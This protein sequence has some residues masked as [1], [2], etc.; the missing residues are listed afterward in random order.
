MPYEDSS[1]GTVA[2]FICDVYGLD[3]KPFV[4][5]PRYILKTALANA[6][7]HGIDEI[8]VG[9]EQE[10][11][12][13]KLD[14]NGHVTSEFADH[15][16]YFDNAPYD[17]AEV[18][19]REICLELTRLGFDVE[20]SHHEVGPGQSEINFK[21]T[22]ALAACD[23]VQT[24]KQVCRAIAKKHGYLASFM[25]KPITGQAGTGM[26]TNISVS[27]EKGNNLFYDSND[28]MQL[29]LLC[30]KW[31]SSVIYHCRALAL[32]TNPTVN[33]YKRL[34]SGYEA[35]IYAC[36]SEANR[37]SLIRIPSAR[38]NATRV[39]LRNVDGTAN[40]YLAMAGIITVG[41]DGI[42]HISE[43][44]LVPPT[45]DNLFALSMDEIEEKGIVRLPQTLHDAVK[46]FKKSKLVKSAVG[47]HCANKLIEAKEKEWMNYHTTVSE[48]EI[49]HFLKK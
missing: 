16:S 44:E 3:G 38:G 19:R 6:K 10:F 30:K 24:F 31:I 29:S 36:W 15:A 49:E 45:K 11:Y 5:D 35:P 28:S 12:L 40:P 48:W 7:K 17:T 4:G 8:D 13:F 27:D 18:V 2:R 1:C 43:N 34:V 20:T 47:E 46:E 37:S 33:S 9:F 41:V 26:H 42:C 22:D 21:Y 23:N 32:L 25:P 39:E 14:N